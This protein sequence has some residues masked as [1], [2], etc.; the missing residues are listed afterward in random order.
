ML[1]RNKIIKILFLNIVIFLTFILFIEL[2][3]RAVWTLRSCLDEQCDFSKLNNLNVVGDEFRSKNIGLSK[4]HKDLGYIPTPGFNKIINHGNYWNNKTVTIDTNGYRDNNNQINI[5]SYSILAVGDSFTFGDQ[6][7]NNE[8]WPSCIERELNLKV[9]NAGAFGY[10]AAQAVKRAI[11]ESSKFDFKYV[12]LSVLVNHNFERDRYKFRAGHPRPAVI[13]SNE[14]ILWKKVPSQNEPGTRFNENTNSYLRSIVS[15]SL[16][17]KYIFWRNREIWINIM[18]PGYKTVLAKNAASIDEIIN[19]TIK[20]FNELKIPNKILLLQYGDEDLINDNEDINN[21]RLKIK[22]LAD[23]YNLD[24]I[25]TYDV[26]KSQISQKN[27]IWNN[28]HTA[29]GNLI[30]CNAIINKSIL[31]KKYSK[32]YIQD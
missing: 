3:A 6:V 5:E 17:L 13:N 31:L 16:I 20:S 26:L 12:I 4:Y 14:K 23:H 25:D 29:F 7:N 10:G 2:T 21:Y 30:I 22:D 24:I 27:K 1:N 28:H 8:T 18:M 11:I 9:A 15:S 32:N 19:F